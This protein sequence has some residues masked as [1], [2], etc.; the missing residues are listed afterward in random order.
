MADETIGVVSVSRRIEAPA[1]RI[2][3]LLAN[4]DRHTDLDGSGMLRG[5]QGAKP[6][7]GVGDRFIMNM[8][9]DGMGGDYAM[10]NHVVDFEPGR[11]IAWTPSGAD[12]RVT[13]RTGAEIG[14][15]AGHRWSFDLVP[16]GDATVVTETYDCT[17]APDGLRE[18]VAQGEIW[19][20]AMT[21]TLEKLDAVCTG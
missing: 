6:I 13:S 11:R 1:D 8:F 3:A 19:R 9:F 15:P 12:N 2:F 7:T 10:D 5:A 14:V 16:D 18:N 4:P 17:A 21:A 20:G